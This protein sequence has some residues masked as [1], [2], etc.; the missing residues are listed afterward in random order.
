MKA[1]GTNFP[2]NACAELLRKYRK[3]AKQRLDRYICYSLR[4]NLMRLSA[5]L[6]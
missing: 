1:G 3:R 5:E 2:D 4:T 6:S